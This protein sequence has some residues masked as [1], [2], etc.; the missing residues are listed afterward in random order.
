MAEKN[1]QSRRQGRLT[2]SAGGNLVLMT[3][4]G[5]EAV[6]ELFEFEITGLSDDRLKNP[7]ALIGEHATVR[8]ETLAG[9]DRLFDGIVT[10]V[11]DLGPA[12]DGHGWGLVLRPWFW[13][14]GHRRN[15]RIFHNLTVLEIFETVLGDHGELADHDPRLYGKYPKLEYTVQYRESD[16]DFL[17]RLLEE[18]GISF[19]F[20]AAEGRHT[21][22]LS[23]SPEGFRPIPGGSRPFIPVADRHRA[24]GEHFSDWSV[25]S[26]YA[27]G[28]VAM[29]DYDF[30]NPDTNMRV[31]TADPGD[32]AH[33][34]MESYEYTGF[35]G[36]KIDPGDTGTQKARHA[37]ALDAATEGAPAPATP[38]L[39][40]LPRR[41]AMASSLAAALAMVA[42]AMAS[43]GER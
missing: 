31:E 6:N 29:V 38:L 28:Q 35:Y 27:T 37:R 42:M 8:I 30:R 26:N 2:L 23:D 3:F 24:T 43:V 10:S 25:R 16:L 32:H 22:V 4:S 34:G 19:H 33:A 41:S 1:S 5:T 39:P 9:G 17:R 7:T 11:R 20:E 18:H 40:G 13:L 12:G 14:L 15:A 36:S 21:M